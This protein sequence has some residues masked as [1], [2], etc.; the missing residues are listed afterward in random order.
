MEAYITVSPAVTLHSL[1][2]LSG[3]F[4]VLNIIFPREYDLLLSLWSSLPPLPSILGIAWLSGTQPRVLQLL[5]LLCPGESLQ[6]GGSGGGRRQDAHL[7]EHEG[8]A[9]QSSS[10]SHNPARRRNLL[11]NGE[12]A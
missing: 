10:T 8:H 7:P 11:L 1:L 12:A 2:S 6:F 4:E 3:G 5:F 9:P